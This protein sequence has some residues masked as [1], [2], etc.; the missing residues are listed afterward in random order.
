LDLGDVQGTP[1]TVGGEPGSIEEAHSWMLPEQRNRGE[2]GPGDDR[3]A[4]PYW[5]RRRFPRESITLGRTEWQIDLVSAFGMV[6]VGALL[7]IMA[8]VA[9]LRRH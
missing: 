3:R 1:R 5:A 9:L 4:F 7:R 8:L 6:V 2:A